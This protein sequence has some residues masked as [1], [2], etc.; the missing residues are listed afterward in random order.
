MI[1]VTITRAALS[2]PDL[3]IGEHPTDDLWVPEDGVGAV[4]WDYRRTYAQDSAYVAGKALL[5]AIPEASTL[6]LIIYATG[7]SSAA[8]EVNKALLN[9]AL[10]QWAYTITTTVDGVA[11]AYNAEPCIP[12]WGALDSGMVRARLARASVSVPVNP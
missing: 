10:G 3:V 2:L 5:A 12:T 6:P 7:A 11:T 1:S 8:V 4:G 9:A